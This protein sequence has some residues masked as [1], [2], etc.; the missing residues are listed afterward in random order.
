MNVLP[1][2]SGRSPAS[3]LPQGRPDKQVPCSAEMFPVFGV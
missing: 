1:F 2:G 3:C